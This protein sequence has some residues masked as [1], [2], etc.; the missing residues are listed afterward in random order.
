MTQIGAGLGIVGNPALTSLVGLDNI[1]GGSIF[2]LSI[3]E[4]PSLSSCA[5]KSICDYLVSPDGIVEIQDNAQGCNSQEELKAAC[6]GGVDESAA[7]SQQ[8]AVSIFPDPASTFITIEVPETIISHNITTLTIYNYNGKQIIQ[9]QLEQPQAVVD[10]S[11]LRSGIYF[12]KVVCDDGVM[13]GK[14]VKQ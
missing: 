13:A 2:N 4:N 3:R 8:P 12:V 11:G 7:G 5:V 14:F 10:V 9:I 1:H 6:E